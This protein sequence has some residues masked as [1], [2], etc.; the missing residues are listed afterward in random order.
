MS[1]IYKSS[2]GGEVGPFVRTITGDTGA[3][4]APNAAGN[5]NV[6]G[7]SSVSAG[8]I[9]VQQYSSQANT[10]LITIPNGGGVSGIPIVSNSGSPP[11]NASYGV[12]SAN[13]GGTGFNNIPVGQILTG[14]GGGS[15]VVNLISTDFA[16]K[17]LT[18]Q[19]NAAQPSWQWPTAGM[20]ADGVVYA[21]G[22]NSTFA[23]TTA[24]VSGQVLTSNGPGNA[25][26][27]QAS[28]SNIGL[29]V[30]GDGSDGSPTWDGSTVVLGITPSGN[31]YTLSRDIFLASSTINNGVSIICNAYRIFCNGTLTNNGTIQWNGN[32]GTNTGTGGA[33]L[34]N[35]SG[36]ISTNALVGSTGGT[37]N[38]GAGGN[39][40]TATAV[41]FGSIGGNGGG[42]SSGGGSAGPTTA[43]SATDGSIRAYPMCLSRMT[44]GAGT[45][46]G[47]AGGTGGGG[48]GGDA[49][50]V[51]GGGGSGGGIVMVI[52]LFFAGTGNIQALGGNGGNGNPSGTDCGGGGGGGGG[53]VI[54][55]S[56]S[57]SSATISGQ[58]ISVAGGSPGTA[59]GTGSNGLVGSA[60]QTI[61]LAM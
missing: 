17:V 45:S 18:A 58:T 27:W 41:N 4:V 37:G 26:T 40:A 24:G 32:A 50:H 5:I 10:L 48:G 12:A 23:S 38:T 44:S 3:A 36:S 35:S 52:A 51:G 47:F 43:L 6:I 7:D 22:V 15:Q 49:T 11:G 29:G 14:A 1:Q 34:T 56:R 13:G 31:T 59:V 30:F 57:V 39:G 53:V 60:G 20:T 33:A 21:S 16:G 2:S 9:S 25:P 55:L 54:V 28:A 42:G 46:V 8:A 61:I 19:G